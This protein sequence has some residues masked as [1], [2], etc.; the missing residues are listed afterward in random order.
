MLAALVVMLAAACG[1]EG[2]AG[3]VGGASSG[4]EPEAAGAGEAEARPDGMTP[5]LRAAYIA[6]V[7]AGAPDSYRFTLEANGAVTA[8]CAAHGLKAQL[9]DGALEL[10]PAAGPLEANAAGADAPSWWARLRWSGYGRGE[11]LS[12]MARAEQPEVVHNRVSYRR[13]A[14]E[15]WYL[16]GPLG[17]EQGFVLREPPAAGDETANE[18]ADPGDASE[19]VLTIA[20][21][22][23]LSAE[24]G[25]DGSMRLVDAEGVTRLRYGHL[26]VL[27]A[28]G[29]ALASRLAT[30]DSAIELRIDDAGARYPLAIDPLV[31]AEEQKLLASD[32][33]ASDGFG[34]SVSVTGDTAVV[35]ASGD[36][37]SGS[38]SGS[39][40]VFAL[41]KTDGEPCAQDHECLGGLCVDGVCCNSACGGGLGDDCQACSVA[42]GA[43]TDGVCGP[44]TGNSCDDGTYCNGTETC[45]AGSCGSSTGDPCPGPDSD[46]DCAESCDEAADS[47]TAND[48]DGEACDNGTCQDGACEGAGGGGQ[49]GST[50]GGGSGT[51]GSSSGAGDSGGGGGCGCRVA[52]GGNGPAPYGPF[53]LLGLMV[54]VRRRRR[55]SRGV[56]GLG[57]QR[58]RA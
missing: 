38:N 33:A 36:D 10:E 4:A 56:H 18:V 49:G 30:A 8:E 43:A 1:S 20:V 26:F 6:A 32:A 39:A 2:G 25:A 5:A 46:G 15:E 53:V 47:C 48:P 54:L 24:P 50:G 16:N 12:P 57:R 11:A 55:A 27:D 40:Y 9:L 23:T 13:G 21:E 51:G 35:G 17:V 41:L 37:D 44:T 58:V 42:E 52:G 22:G 34:Y 31:W 28:T 7:Q 14:A 19:L 29:R 45:T 3:A